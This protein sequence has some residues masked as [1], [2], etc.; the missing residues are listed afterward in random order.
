LQDTHDFFG[1][2]REYGVSRTQGMRLAP[3]ELADQLEVTTL[4]LALEQAA[5]GELPIMIFVGNPGAIQIH[6]GPVTRLVETGPWFNVLDPRFNLHLR[7]DA[8]AAAWR[9]RKPTEDGV[10]TSLELFDARGETIALLF[11]ERKPGIPEDERW[12]ALVE[13]LPALQ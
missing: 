4:R 13:G 12:R 8:I 10:V 5:A 2:L 6:T 7:T 1:L 9:V 11:G 3:P